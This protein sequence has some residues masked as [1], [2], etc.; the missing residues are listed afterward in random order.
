MKLK[1]RIKMIHYLLIVAV[2]GTGSP[3]ILYKRGFSYGYVMRKAEKAAR[4]GYIDYG[5]VPER[6]WLTQQGI[7]FVAK[8]V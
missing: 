4:K 8:G 7:E 3:E 1:K 6:G 2:H 5:V